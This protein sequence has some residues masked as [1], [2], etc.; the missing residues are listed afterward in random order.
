MIIEAAALTDLLSTILERAGAEPERARVCA[1]HLVAANLKG[2]DSHGVGMAP[3]YVRWIQAGK[4][5]PN[6]RPQVVVDRGAVL[7]VDGHFGLGQPVARDAME[8]AIARA[9]Q[10]GISCLALRNACHIG[11]IGTYGEQSA[12]AGLISMHYVNVVGGGPA[13]APFGG[14]EPRMLTNPYCC[15]IPRQGGEHVVLDFATSAIAIGKL[16]VAY[17]KGE[18]VQPGALVEPSGRPTDDPRTFFEGQARSL[19]LPFGLHKGGGM[20]ILCELLGGALAGEWT[21]R[22]ERT[23]AAAV[24]HMLAIVI[25]PDAFGGRAAFEAEA[26]AMLAYIRSTAPAEGVDR[27]RLPGDPERTERRLSPTLAAASR[28]DRWPKPAST[29]SAASTSGCWCAGEAATIRCW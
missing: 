8:V 4:L 16:R 9:K 23:F 3:A 25:D 20:Q 26:E 1:E 24:N 5:Q 27:V 19:L 21:M 22:P 18:Q 15:A 6:A 11:R 14:R 17:M 13:V 12:D 2:H 29:A 7:V 28:P 10:H